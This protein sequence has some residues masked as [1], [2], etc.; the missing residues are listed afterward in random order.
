MSWMNLTA[1]TGRF[2]AARRVELQAP[3]HRTRRLHGHNFQATA[4]ASLPPGWAQFPGAEV[5]DLR[6]RLLETLAPLDY[7]DLNAVVAQPSDENL[8]RWIAEHLAVP[9]LARLSLLSTPQQGVEF[10]PE[11]LSYLW[12]RYAFQAAHCLPRVPAGHKCGRL[13]GH[14]FEVLLH[15]RA[16]AGGGTRVD[17]DDLDRLWAPWGAQ[18]D[19]ACLNE[20]DGLANPTSELLAVW[21]WK[22]L[23]PAMA[24][25][26]WVTVYETPSC[27]ANYDGRNVRIW[28][29]LSL[30]S[31][32]RLRRAPAGSARAGVHG[33]T[34]QLRLHLS[35]PLDEVLG[36][37]MDFGDVKAVFQPT[38]EALDH[39]PLHELPGLGDSDSGSLADWIFRAARRELP[40][41]TGVELFETPGCGAILSVDADGPPLPA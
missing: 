19:G 34:F 5:G 38:F 22:R 10:L 6:A 8:A 29:E 18:L 28:K 30:D 35:A 7:A 25:L 17:H 15:A 41:L 32:V 31:A 11:G 13:H 9:G 12:R 36:W 16:D 4:Y 33:H 26:A 3:E 23:H 1:A 39:R 24:Q 2:A 37:A 14:G 40:Q 27:G 20:I 21:L